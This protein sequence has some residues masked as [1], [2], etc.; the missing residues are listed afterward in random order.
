MNKSRLWL[1][2]GTL[3][4]LLALVLGW[5]FVVSPQ[6]AKAADL[7]SQADQIVSANA[8]LVTQIAELKREFANLPATQAQLAQYSQ[9]IPAT[10]DL[11]AFLRQLSAAG[12]ASQVNRNCVG[13]CSEITGFDFVI[14]FTDTIWADKERPG[15]YAAIMQV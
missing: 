9:R 4:A 1:A 6:R 11:S 8:S 10:A 15:G 7:N 2:G 12:T 13:G 5:L 3:A 14:K